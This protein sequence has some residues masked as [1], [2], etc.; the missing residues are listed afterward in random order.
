MRD[1]HGSL[2]LAKSHKGARFPGA[3]RAGS[4]KIMRPDAV[5]TA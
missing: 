1:R 3:L 2:R 5:T 4:L